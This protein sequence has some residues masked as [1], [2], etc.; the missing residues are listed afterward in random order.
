MRAV[1]RSWVCSS[2]SPG[3]PFVDG[4][5]EALASLDDLAGQVLVAGHGGLG[6]VHYEDAN[7]GFVD[8]GE[9]A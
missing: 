3:V 6:G 7:I 4:Q 2:L 5:D 1:M 9:G 8:G